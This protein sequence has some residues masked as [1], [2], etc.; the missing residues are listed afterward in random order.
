VENLAEAIRNM[1]QNFWRLKEHA[2]QQKR[3]AREQFSVEKFRH[4]LIG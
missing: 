4:G 2:E 3:L 1:Q